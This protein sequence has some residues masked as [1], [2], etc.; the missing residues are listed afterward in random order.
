VDYS[1][2]DRANTVAD[3]VDDLIE[4]WVEDGGATYL[5][6]VGADPIVPFYRVDDPTGAEDD[7]L[8]GTG[9]YQVLQELVRHDG[10]FSDA[11]YADLDD[12]GWK[13]HPA[14]LAVGRIVGAVPNDMLHFIESGR[15]PKAPNCHF[16]GASWAE[17]NFDEEYDVQGSLRRFGFNALYDGEGG[18]PIDII[19]DWNDW[20]KDDLVGA[21]QQGFAAMGYS[22]HGERN[23][24][25]SPVRG[26]IGSG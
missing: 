7:H 21:M 26:G 8:Y 13:H 22:G 15:T 4:D 12:R 17:A 3:I 25:S 5:L 10:F 11:K 1:D 16:V 19:D 24:I 14:D 23:S 18:D 2:W 20:H 6:I 9:T